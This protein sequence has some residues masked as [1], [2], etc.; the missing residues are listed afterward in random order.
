VWARHSYLML[1]SGSFPGLTAM[2]WSALRWVLEGE[3]GQVSWAW[4]VCLPLSHSVSANSN[5]LSFPSTNTF[6][7]PNKVVRLSLQ[8][9][10]MCFS[11]KCPLRKQD[12]E[13]L[14]PVLHIS[15]FQRSLSFVNWYVVSWKPCLHI[16]TFC[17]CMAFD[18]SFWSII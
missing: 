4:S 8:F 9:S 3:S 14:E 7:Q 1:L 2:S 16:Y 18:T 15:L 5:S 10:S 12:E 11:L 17:L 13:M 6:L